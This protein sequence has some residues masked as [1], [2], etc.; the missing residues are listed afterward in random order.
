MMES[1]PCA[2]ASVQVGEFVVE[3]YVFPSI[4]VY[5]SQAV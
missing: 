4:H 2:L 1:H 5:E 3:V